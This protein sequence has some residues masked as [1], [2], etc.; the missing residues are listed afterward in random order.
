MHLKQET[1]IESSFPNPSEQELIYSG[2]Q[3]SDISYFGV[4]KDRVVIVDIHMKVVII[5]D[6]KA[7]CVDASDLEVW[8]NP[9]A[10]V[11]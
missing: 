8:G 9:M 5:T 6:G 10:I 7:E 4:L 2:L 11:R 1:C 3:E